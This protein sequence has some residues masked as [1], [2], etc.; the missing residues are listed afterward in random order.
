M[1]LNNG[2]RVR[3]VLI[4]LAAALALKVGAAPGLKPNV[5]FILADDLGYG[6]LSCQNPS[7]KIRTPR[8]DS[9]AAQ[10]MLFT[11]AH[12]PSSLC[13]PS[14]YSIITGQFCWRSRLK[15]GVLN[16]WDEPLLPPERL[17]VAGFLRDHGYTSGC[18]GKWHLG[19]SWPFFGRV[20]PGFD[21]TVTPAAIDWSRR[22]SG[23]P[24][25]RGFDYFFGINMANQPPY[26]YIL[27]DH[28]VGL[29]I[30][31]YQTV[32]GQQSHWAGPGVPGWNWSLV[33]PT[34]VSNAACWLQQCANQA[35][36]HP[37]FLYLALPGPHQPVVPTAQFEGTSHAGIY[38]DYVQELDY[39]VGQVLDSLEL[40]GAATNTLV[41][42]TSDNG[43][44]EFTYQRLQQYG[45]SS[46]G[47][48]RGIKNDLWEGGHRVPFIARW[49]GKIAAGS[50]STQTI[51]HVDFMRT[52]ADI[53]NTQLP[54]NAAE[55]SISFLPVLL[56]TNTASTRS[57]L[58]VE[59]GPGQFG[60]WTNNWMFIDSFTG[61]GHDP[62]LEP[63][64]FKQSRGYP[65][66]NTSPALLY[67]L[68]HDPA[69]GTNLYARLLSLATQLQALLRD[70]RTIQTWSG[71]QSG[72]WSNCTNWSRTNSPEGCD[73]IYSNSTGARNFTQTLGANFSINS[74]SLVAVKQ[75]VTLWPGGPFALVISNGIDMCLAA[76]DLTIETPIAL[77]QSQIWAV[78]SNR[79]LTIDAPILLNADELRICGVG[80]VVLSNTVSGLGR[81]AIRGSG[82]VLLGGTNTYTGGSELSGGG[83]LVAQQDQALGS[84]GLEIPNNSTLQVEPGVSLTNPVQIAGC[85]AV[86]QDIPRGAIT[87]YHP[88]YANLRGPVTLSADTGLY[89]H[90]AGGILT[91]SGPISGSANL[92]IMPGT[93]TVVFAANNLYAGATSIQ[94]KLKLAGGAN[95]LPPDT[96][97]LLANSH[98]AALDLNGNGQTVALL[99]GGGADGGNV[100][101]GG[102]TLVLNQA[103]TST[104]AGSISGQGGVVKTNSGTLSLTGDSSYTG[105]TMVR[106]GT[107]LINGTLGH[108]SIVVSGAALGG[109]GV[110]TGPVTIQTSGILSP[111][112][113]FGALTIS[114][115][116]TLTEGSTTFIKLD[117]PRQL[118][119]R[120]EG[121]GHVSYGG[122]LLINNLAP[123]G[124]LAVGQCFRI[125]SASNATGQFS[126]IYPSPGAGLAWRFSTALGALSV[127]NE[128]ILSVIRANRHGLMVSWSDPTFH[129]QIQTNSVGFF[130][131][132]FD[133]PG[134]T[135]SPV[136]V[137]IDP[138]I[139]ALFLRL[140]SP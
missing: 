6:D 58:V 96:H 4:C 1:R 79:T 65:L 103:E 133:L 54:A 97:V 70:Q 38:G 93:G 109:T 49:P 138:S 107:L 132:W 91:F 104:Y 100:A 31:Q 39:A 89:A 121:V 32:T 68:V 102:G 50:T 124:T 37:F 137:A 14:R 139:R 19:L 24:V 27:N 116:L 129:L 95:R 13:T 75:P 42:F 12:A 56:G 41:I 21:T 61:D 86:F 34:V 140:V 101:L 125:F 128:P 47:A 71:A 5:V 69:E 35:P 76:S 136:T 80:N 7:S 15:S 11:S 74:L 92:T 9:L 113:E 90:Q 114:N 120:V 25:D 57:S 122:T 87:M 10:G 82:F 40:S 63:I 28:V 81:L 44:D 127:I 115:S 126:A 52:I 30:S 43:P 135:T 55:D 88:G 130:T 123:P 59:S 18:F 78:C 73:L 45:H 3:A 117:P 77:A 67:D 72:T 22:I 16:M 99:S 118:F 119:P 53:L 17:T 134:T 26:A 131:N 108:S 106:A 20:P 36:A 66:T 111:G 33:L 2:V 62:E 98:A 51:C 8:L 48:L 85:G 46:M 110:I 83:F 29:P 105:I 23:G 112:A 64:W 94:G 84:G 60:L